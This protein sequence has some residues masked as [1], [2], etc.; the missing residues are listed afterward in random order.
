MLK[1]KSKEIS[2]VKAQGGKYIS[3]ESPLLIKYSPGPE[4]E[5]LYYP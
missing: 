4:S 3:G 5:V 2:P 1:Q